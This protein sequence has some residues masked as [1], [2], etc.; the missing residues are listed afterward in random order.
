MSKNIFLGLSMSLVS[1]YAL[2]TSLVLR[3]DDNPLMLGVLRD[4]RQNK[5]NIGANLRTVEPR[6]KQVPRDWGN[7]FVIS[8][9]RYIEHLD[10]TKFGKIQPTKGKVRGGGPL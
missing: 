3:P 6:F 7:L 1:Y 5:P 8:R 4:G 2:Q 9:V 10:F